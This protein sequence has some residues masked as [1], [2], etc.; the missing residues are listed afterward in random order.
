VFRAIS[1]ATTVIEKGSGPSPS[2]TKK[3]GTSTRS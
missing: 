3:R 1:P 2:A